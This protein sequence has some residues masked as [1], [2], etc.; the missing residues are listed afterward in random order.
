MKSLIKLF[1][2]LC[3]G[4]NVLIAQQPTPQIWYQ[5]Q[6]SSMQNM[7]DLYGNIVVGNSGV[8]LKRISNLQYEQVTSGTNV[9]LYSI[10]KISNPVIITGAN[11]V[12]L[13]GDAFATSFELLNTGVSEDLYSAERMLITTN[14]FPIRFFAV[15]KNGTII[16]SND[17]G[18]TWTQ[19]TSPVTSDL[20]KLFVPNGL[21]TNGWIAGNGGVV[22]RTTDAGDTWSIVN[23]PVTTDL[24]SVVFTSQN[25]GYVTSNNGLILKT[26]NAGSSW[27]QLNTGTTENL[28]SIYFRTGTNGFAV[29]ENSIIL[30]TTNAGNTWI[31]DGVILPGINFNSISFASIGLTAGDNGNIFYRTSDTLRLPYKFFNPNRI[32]TWFTNR[33]IFNQDIRSNNTP[34]FQWPAGSGKYASFTS[35][36]SILG[37]IDGQLRMAAA[38]YTGEFYLGRTVNGLFQTNLDFRMYRVDK[39]VPSIDSENWGKAVQQGAPY[40]DVNNNGQYDPGIDIPGM[41]N[42]QQTFFASYSVKIQRRN[43]KL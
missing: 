25:T 41:K 22:L 30:Q 23:T 17:N 18:E 37:K 15:G 4:C 21:W 38:S 26:T 40:V 12:I 20:N 16:R 28:K 1:T 3:F 43:D 10:A 9:N 8:I 2:F 13:K 42:A 29:G 6:H 7:N 27:T 32:S 31:R 36:L 35:G 11:G 14:P 19:V 39:N 34:G 33:G 5:Y 24:T